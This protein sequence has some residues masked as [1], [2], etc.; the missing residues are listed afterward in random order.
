MGKPLVTTDVPGCR[1]TVVD[2]RNGYLCQVRS[3]A[4][5]AAKM[6]QVLRLS[7]A[8]LRGMG[9]NSRYLAETKFDEKLVLDQYLAA[10]AAVKRKNEKMG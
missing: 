9:Q 6:L 2:G 1:E 8:D 10:V 7:D 4:D 3:G 5:L